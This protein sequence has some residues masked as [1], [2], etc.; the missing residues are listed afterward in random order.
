MKTHTMKNGTVIPITE[1]SDT[2]LANTIHLIEKR[3]KKG[4][5]VEKGGG[6][7][8]EENWYECQT[9]TGKEALRAMGY[10]H[11]VAEQQRRTTK[12]SNH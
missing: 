9:V 2:H 3:A 5:V 1:M 7:E 4:V 11:Y 8:H 12:C 10:H 6:R